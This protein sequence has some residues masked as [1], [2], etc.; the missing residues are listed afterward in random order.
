MN[1]RLLV[2][3]FVVSV[4]ADLPAIEVLQEFEDKGA[5]GLDCIRIVSSKVEDSEE[6][7]LDD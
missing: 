5:R 3:Q 4:P 1:T 7:E 6:E 2:V